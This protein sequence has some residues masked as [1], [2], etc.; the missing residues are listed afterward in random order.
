MITCTLEND[1]LALLTQASTIIRHFP[2]IFGQFILAA[3][4]HAGIIKVKQIWAKQDKSVGRPAGPPQFMNLQNV[5]NYV[6][7]SV[8]IIHFWYN[9]VRNYL[10]GEIFLTNQLR[11]YNNNH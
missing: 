9:C 2:A 10:T 11:A 8:S 5:I 3:R 7:L 6:L 1:I 4:S